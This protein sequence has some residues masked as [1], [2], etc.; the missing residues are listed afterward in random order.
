MFRVSLL[1]YLSQFFPSVFDRLESRIF[2]RECVRL[3]VRPFVIDELAKYQQ[4]MIQRY[5]NTLSERVWCQTCVL[6]SCVSE[7]FAE[8]LLLNRFLSFTRLLSFHRSVI[9]EAR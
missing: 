6:V 1:C 8:T 4:N 9:G 3:S 5:T 2:I 7:K